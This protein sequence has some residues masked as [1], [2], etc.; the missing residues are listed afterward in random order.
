M[1]ELA[2][3]DIGANPDYFGTHSLRFG[4]ASAL[5]NAYKDTGLVQRWGRWASSFFQGYVWESRTAATGV[6]EQMSRADFTMV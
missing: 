2:A 1:I 3:V 5:Y 4:G 6:A